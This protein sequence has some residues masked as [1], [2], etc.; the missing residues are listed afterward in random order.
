MKNKEENQ[1]EMFSLIAQWRASRKSKKEFYNEHGISESKFYYWLARSNEEEHSSGKF[2]PLAKNTVSKS[3][4]IEIIYP[5]GVRL[6]VESDL[7]L[8]SKLIHLY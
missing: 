5:N 6:Q 1:A 4:E 7:S 8:L 2:I 3:R